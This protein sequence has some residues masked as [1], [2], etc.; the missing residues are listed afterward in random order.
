M[1]V[2]LV[3]VADDPGLPCLEGVAVAGVDR[4]G[5]VTV[6]RPLSVVVGRRSGEA[7]V[8]GVDAMCGAPNGQVAADLAALQ[9]L[10]GEL[11]TTAPVPDREV[12]EGLLSDR[13][14]HVLAARL[15]DDELVGCLV[16]RFVTT[17]TG[18]RANVDD[19]V[20]SSQHRGTGVGRALVEAALEAGH[21]R[22]GVRSI[23][24]TSA[25]HRKPARRL[26]ESCG[27]VARDSQVF[28]YSLDRPVPAQRP[29]GVSG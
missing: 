16:I 4:P 14:V 3:D 8:V 20:V 15:P 29:R 12:V 19:V 18:V 24:L 10:V 23:D 21:E 13:D 7:A 27:F 17:L 28:R 2:V 25:P 1:R 22:T 9:R 11:S 26:H 6:V 5:Q